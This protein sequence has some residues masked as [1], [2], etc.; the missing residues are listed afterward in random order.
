MIFY[1]IDK[2]TSVYIDTH[3]TENRVKGMVYYE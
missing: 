1:L 3:S 2:E